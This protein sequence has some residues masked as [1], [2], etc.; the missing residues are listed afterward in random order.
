MLNPRSGMS[1]GP[2]IHIIWLQMDSMLCHLTLYGGVCT[3]QWPQTPQAVICTPE[4]SVMKARAHHRV[5]RCIT[6]IF[7]EGKTWTH[8]CFRALS[9]TS[10]RHSPPSFS[11]CGVAPPFADSEAGP[12]LGTDA[13][14]K[15]IANL[16]R[17][18]ERKGRNPVTICECLNY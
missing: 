7:E 11:P 13:Q 8:Q 18:K 16:E 1:S 6:D 14:S 15:P 4:A 5:P 10:F 3:Q 12:S 17:E 2:I 9:W